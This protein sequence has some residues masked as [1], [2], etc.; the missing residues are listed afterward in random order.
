MELGLNEEQVAL[1]DSFSAL[2]GKLSSPERVREAEPRGFDE[3]LWNAL[4][5]TG[6]VFMA[7]A[8]EHGGWGAE[9]LDLV[10]VAE[11]VGRAMAPAPVIESQVAARLLARCGTDTARLDRVLDGTSI[12]TVAVRGASGRTTAGHSELVPGG[13]ICDAVIVWDG[14]ELRLVDI[15]DD[16][17]TPV[18]NLASAPLADLRT[19]G[20]IVLASGD[21][22]A[23]LFETAIDEWLV[24]TAAAVV[25]LAALAL[26]V[27]CAYAVERRAFGSAI[28]SFQGISH[29]L[30]DDAT[31]IDGAL[32]L[33]RKAAWAMQRDDV[34]GSELAAM[35][36]AFALATAESTTYDA[37]HVHGGYGFMLE[38]DVQM[39]YRRVR[40][41]PR[42]WGDV[43]VANDRVAANRYG[44]GGE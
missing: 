20:G 30:A 10:L 17:R 11:Q 21:T 43:K 9:L 13:S 24:L 15:S 5:E 19:D 34:R 18:A 26:E 6:V 41:W 28:G 12:V 40:G 39:L 42:V 32:L 29:P 37:V 35:A 33:V 23:A 38:Y 8:E 44:H 27:A 7:V 14:T 25:G 36:F 2:L 16:R 4:A 31:N 1:V 22:A 3:E